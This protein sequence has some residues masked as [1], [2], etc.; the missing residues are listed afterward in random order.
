MSERWV[1]IEE[2]E[3]YDISDHGDVYSR[4]ADRLL[5]LTRNTGGIVKVNL[6]RNGQI[7]TRAVRVLV[8]NA[9]I[10]P[11]EESQSDVINLDGDQENNH[12]ENLAWRPHW[13]AWRYTRQFKFEPPIEYVQPEIINTQT[14]ELYPNAVEAGIADGVLWE[15]VYNSALSGRSV[16]PTGAVYQL[17]YQVQSCK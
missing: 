14:G 6:M 10:S 5:S 1:P 2:F 8:A 17:A 7:S 16:Y 9:F 11:P 4:K 12:F 3:D 15:Y 13:Y